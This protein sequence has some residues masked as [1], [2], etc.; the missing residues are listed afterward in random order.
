M[1]ASLRVKVDVG[2]G[3]IGV[4]LARKIGL[5]YSIA[6]GMLFV[7]VTEASIYYKQ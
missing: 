1:K 7:A 5:G 4:V 6:L 3:N 2:T